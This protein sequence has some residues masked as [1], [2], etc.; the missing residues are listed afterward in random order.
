[1]DISLALGLASYVE[2]GAWPEFDQ[3]KTLPLLAYCF[4]QILNPFDQTADLIKAL[5]PELRIVKVHPEGPEQRFPAVR[6]PD[7]K[8]G[9]RLF[10]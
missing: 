10:L 6:L 1:M 9:V 8:K 3:Q 5:L 7:F 2:E 4:D